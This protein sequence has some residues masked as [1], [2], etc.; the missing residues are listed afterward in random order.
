[1]QVLPFALHLHQYHEK[2]IS[3][4]FCR[5]SAVNRYIRARGR[6]KITAYWF[7]FVWKKTENFDTNLALVSV[8][9]K[10]VLWQNCLV[11]STPQFA[12][13]TNIRLNKVSKIISFCRSKKFS[14]LYCLGFVYVIINLCF[15]LAPFWFWVRTNSFCIS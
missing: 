13:V 9:G 15:V 5:R 10:M 2:L 6:S 14:I 11:Q 7:Y 3:L 8:E 12:R 1:M 4:V